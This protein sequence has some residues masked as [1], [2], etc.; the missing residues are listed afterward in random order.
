V[1]ASHGEQKDFSDLLVREAKEIELDVTILSMTFGFTKWG[2]SS[3]E[4]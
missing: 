4:D 3:D 1:T 2:F